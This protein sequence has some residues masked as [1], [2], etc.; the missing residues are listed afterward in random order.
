MKWPTRE[1][2]D[3]AVARGGS[4]DPAKHPTEEFDL[5]SIPAF[6][7]GNPEVARGTEIGSSKKVVQTDDVLL[8]RIVPHIRRAW[9][10]GHQS[11]RRQIA[12]GE[13]IIFRGKE[14]WPN[15][16]KH[17]LVSDPFHRQ[18]MLTVSGVGGSLLRARP[19]EV[20]KI[21]IPLPPLAEQ[22]RIAAI[23]D[24]ADD[25]RTKRRE[26]LTQLDTLLQSTFL[27]M[28]GDPVTNPKG[29]EVRPISET[30]IKV[31]IGPF[32]S[33]LHKH[34][35][36][37]SGVPLINPMHI[38]DGKVVPGE[39]QTVS[40]G[41]AAS[42]Q[43]YRLEFGDVILGRRGEMGR[44]A[45]I[46]ERES[47]MLCGTGSLFLRPDPERFSSEFLSRLLSN[48]SMVRK[49]EGLSQGVTMPNLNR[50]LVGKL[51]IPVPPIMV[52]SDFEV[53]I[54]LIGRQ[55]QLYRD[56]LTELDTLFASLQTRAFRGDL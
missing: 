49:L 7:A 28:F 36:V 29:W 55:K 25:L 22:K 43:G 38:V 12:S 32:G 54:S 56:Q 3:F 48:P 2:G 27:D 13:W 39:S 34:D 45:V 15:Y 14:I 16:V 8:S 4:V 40:P 6:D 17:F 42:L 23:L 41:K 26:S 50:S 30:P 52:Q 51:E 47:G 19:T 37:E 31:Q 5:Y 24:A 35:Y 53:V 20:Y 1:L 10:V 21:E 11:S 18:F 46:S 33:L 44:C 9:I